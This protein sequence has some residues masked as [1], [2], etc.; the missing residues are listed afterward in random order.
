M[1]SAWRIVE[2][3][4][5]AGR[6]RAFEGLFTLGSGGLHVRGSLE[7]HL[8]NEPQNRE[9]VR[10][11]S[12]VT[13][14]RFPDRKAKWGTYVPGLFAR[15]PLLN[16]EMVN[17]PW[18]LDLAPVVG[19]EKLDMETSRVEEYTRV[20]HMKTA[21]LSR[22]LVWRTGAGPVL[23]VRFERFVSLVRPRL[24][25][26]R[27]T[28]TPDRDGRATVLAG[29]DADVRTNGHDHF[30]SVDMERDGERG[31]KCRVRIAG[32][33][34][35]RI[36]SRLDAPSGSW[37]YIG[38]PRSGRCAVDLDLRAG[39]KCVVEKRT[40]LVTS[41]DGAAGPDGCD[42]AGVDGFGAGEFADLG[43][44]ELFGE[45]AD[46]WAARWERS[47]VKIDGDPE[48][49]RALRCSIYHLLRAHAAWDAGAAVDARGYSGDAY[50]GRFFWD[51]EIFLLPFYLYTD[52]ER[53]RALVDFRV[54][55]LSRARKI[56]AAQGFRGARYPWESDDRGDEC[57]PNPIYAEQE[58]HVTGDVVYAMAHADAALGGGYLE[59]PA[60]A[61]VVE[62][63]R[64]WVDRIESGAG[65]ESPGLL[66][67]MGP[68]EYTP[69][70]DNNA[71]TN[72]L[73]SFT[74]DLAAR[75]GRR[76]GAAPGE[77]KT[78]AETARKLPIVRRGG[79]VLQCE[80][81]DLL[82]NPRFDE[83]WIDRDLPF[84][85]QAPEEHLHRSRCLKQADV[86][87]LMALFPDEFSDSEV[88]AAWDYYL[89]VTTHD[90]SLSPSIHAMV[91]LR[92][93]L[94]DEA[95]DFWKRGLSLDLDTARGGAAEGIHI[96]ACGGNWQV[97]VLG[98]GG[99]KSVLQSDDL[100]LQ[101]VLPSGWSR[102][103]FPIV[104]KGESHYIDIT[105]NR[106]SVEK[107]K[108]MSP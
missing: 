85:A 28:L 98:F 36:V 103:A 105:P 62:A 43:W 54:N 74:L 38:E 83:L 75:I 89:P 25:L 86:I 73:A 77:R 56:A 8:H 16:R 34:S 84:A 104:W 71:Y 12:N 78:F 18:F 10:R 2:S 33:G 80:G 5:R 64:Y 65:G 81:F 79:L 21:S 92:L 63:A 106:C 76:G 101:P 23:S 48:S 13:A 15:H 88:R 45:H 95:V 17:L 99:M 46:A 107:R 82:E 59:G 100:S 6:A 108:E 35:V 96:A 7:E 50:F 61:A 47:D 57:C 24:V 27:M 40:A 44:D 67:V 58:V 1:K 70:S 29:I 72:R 49:Q 102:L 19:D 31:M 87:M 66:R 91:A 32:A 4:F 68:D 52:P 14:E 41:R 90:S 97:A 3:P 39:R 55:A 22:S 51:T 30:E 11:P 69:Y 26:Q 94:R 20:L 9:Y 93:G 53:A 37:R 60:A 42:T